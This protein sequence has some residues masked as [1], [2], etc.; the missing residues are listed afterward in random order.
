MEKVSV[1]IKIRVFFWPEIS[2]LRVSLNFDNERMRPPKYPSAPTP[3]GKLCFIQCYSESTRWHWTLHASSRH[4]QLDSKNIRC[5]H[6][7]Q[8]SWTTCS[9]RTENIK[10]FTK[11][12]IKNPLFRRNTPISTFDFLYLIEHKVSLLRKTG[13]IPLYIDKY[14]CRCKASIV[15]RRGQVIYELVRELDV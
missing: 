1:F 13:P 12:W 7:V 2:A 14:G 4:R 3:L 15:K 6:K 11:P 8:Y 10:W 5:I 9:R